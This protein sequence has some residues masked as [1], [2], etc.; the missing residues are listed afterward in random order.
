MLLTGTI[1]ATLLII[2]LIIFRKDIHSGYVYIAM[3][4]IMCLASILGLKNSIAPRMG[5][6]VPQIHH[7]LILGFLMLSSFLPWVI[8]DRKLGQY[9]LSLT[10][11]PRYIKSLKVVII[12]FIIIS[13]YSLIY[14]LPYA[15]DGI[16]MGATARR[17]YIWHHVD[18]MPQ[19]IFTTIA[20]GAAFCFIFTLLLVF[21]SQLDQQLH[22]YRIWLFLSSLSF[23][24]LCLVTMSRD[25]FLFY[26]LFTA[27]Y[28][29]IFLPIYGPQQRKQFRRYLLISASCAAIILIAISIQRF[30]H[31]DNSEQLLSGT[32]GYIAEQPY[33]FGYTLE[34]FTDF[35]GFD[36]CF[37]VLSKIFPI[38]GAHVQ[39]NEYYEIMFA[40]MFGDFYKVAGYKTMVILSLLYICWFCASIWWSAK[41]NNYTSLLLLFAVYIFIQCSGLFYLRIG[42][43]VASNLF[44]L[45][46][47]I[48]PLFA[49]RWI[50]NSSELQQQAPSTATV[51]VVIP[52]IYIGRQ[53][54]KCLEIIST[55]KEI[56]G[57]SFI[58]VTADASVAAELKDIFVDFSMPWQIELCSPG[59]ANYLRGEGVKIVC[60][61]YVFF[62]DCDDTANYKEMMRTAA[63]IRKTDKDNIVCFNVRIN[64]LNSKGKIIASRTNIKRRFS[65]EIRHIEQC[66]TNIYAK[67]IPTE[68]LKDSEFVD[69]PFAED[70]IL[71]Y[72]LFMRAR[73]IWEAKEIYFYNRHENSIAN[74]RNDTLQKI[75]C[76]KK[77]SEKWIADIR[78]SGSE[79]Y[80][81][82]LAM[83]FSIYLSNRARPLGVDYPIHIPAINNFLKMTPRFQASW[84]WQNIRRKVSTA[85][86]NK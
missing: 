47:G 80:T 86:L 23:P 33:V 44:W 50:I 46:V 2:F 14:L 55:E 13:F 74:E 28:S 60:S 77:A 19:N 17:D 35:Y 20:C 62:Q 64:Q 41:R 68:L 3:L 32:V 7:T 61:D 76:V 79:L 49:P 12:G 40:T 78:K 52:V 85:I 83:R 27:I 73:H 34:N 48:S 1:L 59:G 57:L 56:K 10:I 63:K 69:I 9:G 66:P 72:S 5:E 8:A 71:S 26:I 54:R 37:P 43:S 58:F 25:G 53:A 39:H 24:M 18:Y 31:T 42:Y 67:L 36:R 45:F 21:I 51:A 15:L 29:I 70:C 65:G 4:A 82:I 38:Q 6:Y 22:K 30:T 81:D 75:D 84:I 11:N 16:R